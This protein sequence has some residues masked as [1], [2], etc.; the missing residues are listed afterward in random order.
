M[1]LKVIG[2]GFGRTGTTSL[3]AALEILGYDKCHH[4]TEVIQTGS[5]ILWYRK[6]E[7]EDIGWEEIFEGYE[8]TVD[9]PSAAWWKELTDYYP[10]AK[11]ILTVRDPD[12]WYRSITE[13]IYPLSTLM[14]GWL[15]LVIPRLRGFL[16]IARRI[17]WENTFH[18]RIE[19]PAY[20]KR[21][22]NEHMVTVKDTIAPERLLVYEISEGWE[23]LCNFLNVPVP[24][25][26]PFPRVNEGH[27]IK[28]AIKAVRI[29]R[30]LPY[31]AGITVMIGLMYYLIP[32]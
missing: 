2:A 1:P 6:L 21:I 23:P 5:G 31:A 16:K 7:G 25:E 29:I 8:A 11:V 28:K 19:D 13:T 3:K 32:I 4:M 9:W 14:P 27:E 30:I 15:G 20:A 22:F 12:K 26:T 18:G 17:P 24:L 10:D